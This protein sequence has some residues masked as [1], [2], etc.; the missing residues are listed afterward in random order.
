[1]SLNL[2]F[3]D[4]IRVSVTNETYKFIALSLLLFIRY[5]KE[6][7]HLKKMVHKT[8]ALRFR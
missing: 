6:Y 4:T 2:I 8:Q 7:K 3:K 5:F 1:M